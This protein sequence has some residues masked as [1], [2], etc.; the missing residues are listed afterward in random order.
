M[1]RL[2]I[3][4]FFYCFTIHIAWA[5]SFECKKATTEIEKSIC[6]SQKLSD[7]DEYLGRYYAAAIAE[8]KDGAACL[9]ADQRE[10]VKTKRNVCGSDVACLSSAYL[11]RLG[12]LNAMQPGASTLKNIELPRVPSLVAAIPAE[13]DEVANKSTQRMLIDGH[14]LHEEVD[15]HNM[16]YAV[17]ANSGQS[18]AFVFDMN[19]GN[20]ANHEVVRGLIEQEPQSRF[21]VRGWAGAA[22]G[23]DL[24]RCR[25][26]YRIP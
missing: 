20:S 14:L 4:V 1:T 11:T 17:K 26:V 9:N 12:T 6:S 23:F 18:T 2:L 5:A 16:G 25:M 15:I 22:G 13:S 24:G 21:S 7:L 3:A 10:W 8:L 19:I